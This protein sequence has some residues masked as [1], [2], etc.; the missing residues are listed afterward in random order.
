MKPSTPAKMNSAH[1]MPA[2]SG[3]FYHAVIARSDT[4]DA[5]VP[6]DLTLAAVME[7]V[8]KP[9]SS[10]DAVVVGGVVLA[11]GKIRQIR[12]FASEVRFDELRADLY[13]RLVIVAARYGM[14]PPRPPDDTAVAMSGTEVT[15]LLIVAQAAAPGATDSASEHQPDE[16]TRPA[17]KASDIDYDCFICHASEDKEKFVD[18][19]ARGL[20]D[21][22]CSVWYDDFVLKVGDS[23]RRMIDEGLVRSRHGVVVLSAAFFKKEWPQKEL[24]GLA[25]LAKERGILPVWLDIAKED[26]V[27]YSP[28]LA[29]IVATRA[30]DGLVAVIPDLLDAMDKSS[31]ASS[32]PAVRSSASPVDGFTKQE[33]ELLAAAA[34]DGK[35]YHCKVAQIPAGWIRA[36]RH[37]YID[38]SDPAVAAQFVDALESLVSKGYAKHQGGMLYVLTGRGFTAARGPSGQGAA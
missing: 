8:A 19:L 24:D 37:D 29:D 3:P 4:S 15:E 27:R 14:K 18:A 1:G 6:H 2:M 9:Y 34:Q 21:A 17:R 20:R 7:R 30:S 35:L 36:G 22:G 11:P 32:S 16:T 26:I 10:G 12:I 13:G 5:V 31:P 25:A 33:S 23:L 38:K 28:T